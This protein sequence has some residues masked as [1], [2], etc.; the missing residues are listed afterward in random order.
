MHHNTAAMP[1]TAFS[2]TGPA[3]LS[4]NEGEAAKES[5]E[6]HLHGYLTWPFQLFRVNSTWKACR[7]ISRPG[8]SQGRNRRLPES[9]CALL[10]EQDFC[11]YF[12]ILRQYGYFTFWQ[13]TYMRN[14]RLLTSMV[15]IWNS[16]QLFTQ[17]AVT[18]VRCV[19]NSYTDYWRDY[20]NS[21]PFYAFFFFQYAFSYS[22]S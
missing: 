8:G 21:S 3:F 9:S 17:V 22:I 6:I 16:L 2:P 5:F 7:F 1:G 13:Q 20:F 18:H 15:W 11:S 12:A 19:S 10:P 14:N 4:L